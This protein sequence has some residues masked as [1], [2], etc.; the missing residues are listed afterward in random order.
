MLKKREESEEKRGKNQP[1]ANVYFAL[2]DLMIYTVGE[3]NEYAFAL[4]ARY[5][6]L[7]GTDKG[8]KLPAEK[9]LYILFKSLSF[10]TLGR[11]FIW[12]LLLPDLKHWP[13]FKSQTT[14]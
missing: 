1:P 6:A 12:R 2:I 8:N 11:I 9:R 14:P 5:T 13:P 4:G 7:S 10:S 3:F